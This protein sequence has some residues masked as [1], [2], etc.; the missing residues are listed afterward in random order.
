MNT[1]DITV[2][3]VP[4]VVRVTIKGQTIELTAAEARHLIEEIGKV[5][6]PKPAEDSEVARLKAFK[7]AYEKAE[8]ERRKNPPFHF[9]EPMWPEPLPPSP[10]DSDPS[11]PYP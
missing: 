6:N 8:K 2:E 1:P 3:T 11:R 9:H 4:Q 7:E 5:I 10:W